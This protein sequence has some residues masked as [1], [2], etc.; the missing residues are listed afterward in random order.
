MSDAELLAAVAEGL[1]NYEEERR[2]EWKAMS[3][4]AKVAALWD[5]MP[6]LGRIV[7]FFMIPAM[8]LLGLAIGIWAAM[9][10]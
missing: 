1:Q 3:F 8:D 5:D 7:V 4:R 6:W 10:R 2:Q 9:D